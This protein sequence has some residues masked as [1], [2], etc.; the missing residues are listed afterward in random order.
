MLMLNWILA[1]SFSLFAILW[2]TGYKLA[3]T[4]ILHIIIVNA[5]N[6]FPFKWVYLEFSLYFIILSMRPV[7]R[8]RLSWRVPMPLLRKPPR[9]LMSH[10]SPVLMSSWTTDWWRL[11]SA[12]RRT[13]LSTWRTTWRKLSSIWRRTTRLTKWT[14]SRRTSLVS[15]RI[16]WVSR[17]V[18]FILSQLMYL[19]VILNVLIMVAS[20]NSSSILIS[21]FFPD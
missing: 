4:N 10:L 20:V 12:Q 6:S 19:E 8:E 3:A 18:G 11:V 14:H 21:S 1:V 13:S 9:E 5:N 7:K 2:R 16:W 15:W 17:C